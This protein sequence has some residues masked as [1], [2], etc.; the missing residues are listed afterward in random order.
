MAEETKNYSVAVESVDRGIST[1]GLA[2]AEA[3]AT[4]IPCASGE[5]YGTLEFFDIG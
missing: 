5:E 3:R 2:A 4:R 1:P